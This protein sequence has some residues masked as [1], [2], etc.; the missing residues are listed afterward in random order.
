MKRRERV[1][2]IRVRHD[3]FSLLIIGV[4]VIL[5]INI[6]PIFSVRTTLEMGLTVFPYSLRRGGS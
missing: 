1:P 3:W 4:Q 6:L 5:F 2:R